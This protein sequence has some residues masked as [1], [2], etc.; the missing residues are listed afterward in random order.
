MTDIHTWFSLSYS[1]YL[2]LD[3]A[4][5]RHLP[6]EWHLEMAGM[7]DELDRAFPR[8]H[9]AHRQLA[10]AGREWEFGD[11][12]ITDLTQSGITTNL[13]FL[14]EGC[15][16]GEEPQQGDDESD[17]EFCARHRAWQDRR[18]DHELYDQTWEYRG[19][20]YY[21]RD[22]AVFPDETVQQ[23]EQAKRIIV[24]RTLL[25]SM[26]DDWQQRFVRLLQASDEVAD[27]AAPEGY[28]IR[29]YDADGREIDD[30]V[31][32]YSRGRTYIEPTLEV[33][34]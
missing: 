1:N 6:A 27:P 33:P 20:E 18:W 21:R 28:Q 13:K 34:A 26:P 5:T 23:A 11:L 19:E 29:S 24:H 4:T 31:P 8:V 15:E 10:L 32:H 9:R 7:L 14:H 30:P 2:V 17:A 25:Q 3:D 12:D 16:C 22:R